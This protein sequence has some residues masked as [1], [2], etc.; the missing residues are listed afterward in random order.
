[1]IPNVILKNT[2]AKAGGNFSTRGTGSLIKFRF[3][4]LPRYFCER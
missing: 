4:E 2:H 1:M 3:G